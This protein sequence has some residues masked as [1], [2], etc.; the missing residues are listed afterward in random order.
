M[1]WHDGVHHFPWGGLVFLLLAIAF[2]GVMVW[3]VVS[4]SRRSHPAALAPPTATPTGPSPEDILRERLARGEIDP[5][6]YA[7]RLHALGTTPRPG[8]PAGNPPT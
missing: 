1:R 3:L 6:D 8:G 2:V 4:T 7:A 5:E